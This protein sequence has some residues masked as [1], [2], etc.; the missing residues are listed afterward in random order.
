MF[1]EQTSAPKK[2]PVDPR[3]AVRRFAHCRRLGI[4]ALKL[5]DRVLERLDRCVPIDLPERLGGLGMHQQHQ[6]LGLSVRVWNRAI[7]MESANLDGQFRRIGFDERFDPYRIGCF[8][9]RYD[10]DP[11]RLLG[12]AWLLGNT[13]LLGFLRSGRRSRADCAE[14]CAQDR[15]EGQRDGPGVSD[16]ACG[17]LSKRIDPPSSCLRVG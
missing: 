7:E 17:A 16:P 15:R 8:G 4:E 11:A 6:P 9:Q 12:P 14:A 13:R 5:H 3:L 2:L 1:V 10:A